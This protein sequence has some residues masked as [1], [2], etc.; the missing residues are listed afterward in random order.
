VLTAVDVISYLDHW[1]GKKKS[2]NS[3]VAIHFL[4]RSGKQ[5]VTFKL[6]YQLDAEKFVASQRLE[7]GQI[8][9]LSSATTT[10]RKTYRFKLLLILG[11]F[12]LTI[13]KYEGKIVK[14]ISFE[15]F[16]FE[17]IC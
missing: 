17:Y 14:Y 11:N 10:E 16:L 12:L 6:S 9:L 3:K 2:L 1:Y 8:F 4:H 13:P 5:Q 15:Q 7:D